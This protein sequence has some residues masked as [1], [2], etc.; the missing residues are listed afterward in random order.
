MRIDYR[1]T[2]PAAVQAT[3]KLEKAV[4]ASS[5]EPQLLELVKVRASQLNGCGY[6]V[7]MHTKDATAIGVDPQR[8]RLTTVWKEAQVY[9]PRER[10]AFAW[11]ETL[12]LL[13]ESGTPDDVYESMECEFDPDEIVTLTLAIVAINRWNRLALG[14]RSPVGSSVRSWR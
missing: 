2:H 10:A 6:C 8:L 7:E 12:T 1:K 11:C 14:L 4:H 9:S 5:L 3:S 13:P